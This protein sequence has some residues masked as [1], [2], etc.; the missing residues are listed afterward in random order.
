MGKLIDTK[1]EREIIFK[2]VK[3]FRD[4]NLNQ[5]EMSYIIEFFHEALVETD[6]V[7]DELVRDMTKTIFKLKKQREK[8]L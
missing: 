5:K 4:Y 2:V 8:D 3:L 1:L 6:K 7:A